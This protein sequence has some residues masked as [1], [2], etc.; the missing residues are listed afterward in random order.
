MGLDPLQSVRVL[1]LPHPFVHLGAQ[2]L[3]L[4][5]GVLQVAVVW[6]VFGS[7]FQDLH[8]RTEDSS[9]RQRAGL[10]FTVLEGSPQQR[11]GSAQT[12]PRHCHV[13]TAAA[14][15]THLGND[16]EREGHS[17]LAWDPYG[18]RGCQI[19]YTWGMRRAAAAARAVSHPIWIPPRRIILP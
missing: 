14:L 3:C 4:L 5:Q 13:F 17:L 10:G 8:Q 6:V 1:L 19:I 15:S 7:V 9:L 18:G 2:L 16:M 12:F 11:Q